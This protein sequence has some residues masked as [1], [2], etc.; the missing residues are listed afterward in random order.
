MG[1]A[2]TSGGALRLA[3]RQ[4]RCQECSA[5]GRRRRPGG[6]VGPCDSSSDERS[7][8]TASHRAFHSASVIR[9]SFIRSWRIAIATNCAVSWLALAMRTA[10]Q[11]SRV[12]SAACNCRSECDTGPD[13]AE[14]RSGRGDPGGR[15]IMLSIQ[16]RKRSRRW[17]PEVRQLWLQLNQ[18]RH[19]HRQQF[20]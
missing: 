7:G 18:G 15:F 6:E 3:G 16:R 2:E 19:L 1:D 17:A 8:A 14:A 5:E 9:L 13:A 11:C 12:A 10:R 20:A 4:A